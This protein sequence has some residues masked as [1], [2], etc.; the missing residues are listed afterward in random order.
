MTGGLREGSFP[1]ASG[2]TE[3]VAEAQHNA[4]FCAPSHKLRL[5]KVAPGV[6]SATIAPTRVLNK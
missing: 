1:T 2:H 4:F 5:G 3:P 6:F